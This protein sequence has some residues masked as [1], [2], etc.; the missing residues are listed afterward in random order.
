MY[1]VEAL[2]LK[3]KLREFE[4]RFFIR[5]TDW[6]ILSGRTVVLGVDSL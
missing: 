3:P 6:F 5:N 1:F 2:H 4:F